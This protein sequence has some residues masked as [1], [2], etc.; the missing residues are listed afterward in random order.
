MT[1][2]QHPEGPGQRDSLS[3]LIS[4]WAMVPAFVRDRHLTV[5]AANPLARSLSA[6][7]AEGVNLARF[8]FL[9]P[10]ENPDESVCPTSASQVAAMLRDSLDQHE[11]D[12]SFRALVGELSAQSPEFAA[13]WAHSERASQSGVVTLFPPGVGPIELSYHQLLIP[14]A[15]DDVLMV[16]GAIDSRGADALN[17]LS[18]AVG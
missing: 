10:T 4:G 2:M 16:F 8:A 14:E 7:F 5:V 6:G 13:A 15:F 17:R 18:A 3:R 12:S 11:E 9:G 1:D